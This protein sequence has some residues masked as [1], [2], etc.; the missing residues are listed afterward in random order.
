MRKELDEKLCADYPLIFRDRNGDMSKTCM[1]W[2]MCVGDG[3]YNILEAMCSNIQGHIDWRLEQIKSAHKFNAELEEALANGFE[4]WD[5]WKSREPRDIPEP[6]EQVVA[7]QVKEKFGTLRF[8]FGGGDAYID[9]IVSMAESMSG[10]TCEQCG[11]PG[12][13]T[14]GGWIRVLC[15]EHKNA[16]T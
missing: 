7:I 8:Y 11:A 4:N 3:W 1:V 5:S 9:G 14:S 12:T 2:G 13:S 10:R 6:V 15:E 16:S